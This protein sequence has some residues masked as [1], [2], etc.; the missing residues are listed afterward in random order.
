MSQAKIKHKS[1]RDKT[2]NVTYWHLWERDSKQINK[3]M[4]QRNQTVTYF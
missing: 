1:F 2:S 3:Q 4:N